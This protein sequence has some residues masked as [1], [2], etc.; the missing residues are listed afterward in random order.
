MARKRYLGRANEELDAMFAELDSIDRSTKA[1]RRKHRALSNNIRRKRED[2]ILSGIRGLFGS[3]KYPVPAAAT[4]AASTMGFPGVPEVPSI[5]TMA[6]ADVPET[7]ALPE[8][9]EIEVTAEKRPEVEQDRWV[10][11]KSLMRVHKKRE[12]PIGTFN[13]KNQRYNPETRQWE[14]RV[15]PELANEAGYAEG[16]T[17]EGNRMIGE[18]GMLFDPNDPTDLALLGLGMA[19]I[20]GARIAAGAGKLR[21][22]AKLKSAMNPKNMKINPRWTGA[23]TPL[24]WAE[25]GKRAK[26]KRGVTALQPTKESLEEVAENRLWRGLQ[27]KLGIPVTAVGAIGSNLAEYDEDGRLIIGADEQETIEE[28]REETEREKRFWDAYEAN[29]D[30]FSKDMLEYM[31][32]NEPERKAGGG[33][34]MGQAQQLANAGRGEDTM[35]MH[36]TPDEVAGIASLAPGMMTT[37]PQTGLPEAGFFKDLLGFGLPFLM[38]LLLPGVGAVAA[39][40]L[41]GAGGAALRGGDFKDI[42]LGA[43]TGALGG[44]FTEG[45]SQAGQQTAG[46][47]EA[48]GGTDISALSQTIPPAQ[49]KTLEELTKGGM[50]VGDALASMNLQPAQMTGINKALTES[51][52]INNLI[53]NRVV[54]PMQASQNMSIGEGFK[55]IGSAGF[56][57]LKDQLMTPSGI[58]SIVGTG[59]GAERDMWRR[60]DQS[61][62][63][64]EEEKKRKEEE[65][66]R[67]NPENIP[68]RGG[69]SL[70]KNRYINGNWS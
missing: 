28:I 69:G 13:K 32:Q 48:L 10:P 25:I 22:L 64:R 21:K 12:L 26:V 57:G 18:G 43:G 51:I 61:I 55:S 66:Y 62:L 1:G 65:I 37:N 46:L 68:Y 45:L 47:T 14:I 41:G 38:P 20:P 54:N 34:L 24:T 23:D 7:V 11:W 2:R 29:P 67:M 44:K 15:L 58:G 70:Y 6:E 8:I 59:I 30:A 17:I 3:R 52:P 60:F 36:V 63:D 40:A 35:L 53:S 19:P 42:L 5:G 16:R 9:E 27:Y 31:K 39:G 56:G 49:F 50:N 33:Q 4:G